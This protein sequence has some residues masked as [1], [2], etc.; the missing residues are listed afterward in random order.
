[1]RTDLPKLRRYAGNPV[2]CSRP[3]NRWESR[4]VFN[5]ASLY[6]DGKVHLLYR[7]IGEDGISRLG[8]AASRDGFVFD[9][10]PGEPVYTARPPRQTH[11]SDEGLPPFASGAGFHG[12]EDPRL[13]HLGDRIYMTY[14]DFGGWESPPAVALTSIST[15]DF[16]ARCWRW[17]A[18]RVISPAGEVHK[19]WVIFPA[20][21]A[22]RF[23]VLHSLKPDIQIDYVDSL[24]E[25]SHEVIR[26]R[27]F[28]T[29]TESG[30]D[31]WVR[32][33]GAPP[34]ETPAGWLQLYHAMDHRDPDRYKLGALL[35]DCDDP[36][37]VLARLPYP[38]LEPNAPCENRGFKT[39]VVYNCGTALIG[40][41][42]FVYYG[43]ADSVVCV[44][45]VSL[46]ALLDR[47]QREKK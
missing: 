29:G 3:E 36:T 33:A 44:A 45:T 26:S 15:S 47:L 19:N 8:Y 5:A 22:G 27:H 34:V 7:A 41:C 40:G 6:L 32:G 14:T 25:L 35:L 21:F 1:M 46:Q 13:T 23:A 37:R 43:G 28:S 12:C 39:G 17:Q 2:L 11:R 4:H 30:W 10:R 16:L 31:S 38:L 20:T 24:D 42:L 9:E 18:P